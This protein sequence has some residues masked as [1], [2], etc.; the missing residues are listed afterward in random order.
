MNQRHRQHPAELHQPTPIPATFADPRRRSAV[1]L[2]RGLSE[3][4]FAQRYLAG[5]QSM[6][7][8]FGITLTDLS[9]GS[10]SADIM[11]LLEAAITLKV[12]AIVIDHGPPDILLP[13]IERALDLGIKV[14][15]FDLV[16][17]NVNVPLI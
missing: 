16:V 6:A 10:D 15:A 12:D 11:A 3:G 7:D 1:A 14:V 2:V 13:Q 17:D 8:Q 5:A 9:V 4:D